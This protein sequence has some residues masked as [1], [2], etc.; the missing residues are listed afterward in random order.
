VYGNAVEAVGDRRAGNAAC[1]VVRAE[2]EVIDE[3]LRA[4]AEEIRERSLPF[5]G[6]EPVVL[7][8]GDPGQ[9]LAPLRELIALPRQRLLRIEQLEPRRKPL[10]TCSDLVCRHRHSPLSVPLRVRLGPGVA[11]LGVTSVTG[12]RWTR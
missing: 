7:F 9:F 10:F 5:V 1:L 6:V 4:P 8:H 11:L 2:H 3:E 12:F